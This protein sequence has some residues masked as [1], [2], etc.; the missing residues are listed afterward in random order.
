MRTEDSRSVYKLFDDNYSRA[1][2]Q[3]GGLP[4][5]LPAIPEEV[6]TL[7]NSVDGLLV[8]GGLDIHSRHFGEELHPTVNLHEERDAFEMAAIQEA[9]NRD[10]PLL[11]IC[12]GAQL[13]N[14]VLGGSLWQD[15]PGQVQEYEQTQGKVPLNHWHD[16]ATEPAHSV[17]IQRE[18]RLKDIQGVET[19]QVNT[20]H[21]QALKAI[22]RGLVVT[23][24]APD[25]VVE[26]VELPDKRFV[27][28]IQWHPE[29]L[30]KQ[31][32]EHA[33]PFKALVQACQARDNKK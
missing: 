24:T 30:F 7:L 2:I 20:H 27:V 31:Y 32:P 17:S 3:A 25:G 4:L 21:H 12:R 16:P 19:L 28:G 22:G 5:L 9:L 29:C 14:V 8:P 6:G 11:A 15:L 26:G 23:A 13:L 33:R 1:V 10:M 18:S